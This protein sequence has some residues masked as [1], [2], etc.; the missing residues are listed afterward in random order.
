MRCGCLKNERRLTRP[1]ALSGVDF[2]NDR[3]QINAM[4]RDAV[5]QASYNGQVEPGTIMQ[6]NHD[7][8]AMKDRL[9]RTGYDLP[10]S[11]YIEANTFINN[12]NDAIK[13][14]RQPDAGNYF[15]GKYALKARTVPELVDFMTAHGLQFAQATPGDEAAYAALQEALASYDRAVNP[16]IEK[17]LSAKK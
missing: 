9:R 13:A 14:L 2:K 11:L 6:L 17:D 8:T 15:T 10:P 1:V 16:N 7:T 4:I 3:D 5:G 12:L